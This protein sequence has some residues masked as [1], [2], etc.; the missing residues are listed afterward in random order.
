MLFLAC[1]SVRNTLLKILVHV[2][3]PQTWL[4]IAKI[5]NFDF[6]I[7]ILS[8]PWK[9]KVGLP[10]NFLRYFGMYLTPPDSQNMKKNFFGVPQNFSKIAPEVPWFR[11]RRYSETSTRYSKTSTENGLVFL[12]LNCYLFCDIVFYSNLTSPTP[13]VTCL[14]TKKLS[15][16][17]TLWN[18]N[19]KMIRLEQNATQVTP[20]KNIPT[21][22]CTVLYILLALN[23]SLSSTLPY[24][25]T[26]AKPSNISS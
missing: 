16:C 15:S 5:Q 18:K 19:I 11:Y 26:F 25:H 4:P 8:R 14:N 24:P 20:L 22:F 7:E 21:R 2:P 6:Y 3:V 23:I 13:K 10:N 12:G 9:W 1:R 17:F